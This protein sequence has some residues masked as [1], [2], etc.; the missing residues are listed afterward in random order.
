MKHVFVESNWVFEYVE[1]EFT[2][3]PS[4]A[5]LVDRA[6]AG[7]LALHI[8]AICL[9]EG[10]ESVRR[11]CQ[12]RH[13]IGEFSGFARRKGMLKPEEAQ[14]VIRFLEAF[15]RHV[16]EDIHG[17]DARLDDLLTKPNVKAFALSEAMLGRVL[18]LRRSVVEVNQ[19]KPFDEAIL[20]AVLVQAEAERG[21][22][23][24][25]LMF[26]TLDADLLPW[27]KKR[28]PRPALE[29]LYKKAGLTVLASFAVP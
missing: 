13:E 29:A 27:T 23:A 26:C 17:I 8:P 28:E 20:A 5:R 18:D 22:G 12:P 4:A 1:P 9:R 21:S 14:I 24:T 15:H 6:V 11:K 7:E 2:R 19:M 3:K 16:T 10:A 25:D